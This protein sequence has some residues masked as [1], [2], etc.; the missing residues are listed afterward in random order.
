MFLKIT[1]NIF[2]FN[3]NTKNVEVIYYNTSKLCPKPSNIGTDTILRDYKDKQ[4]KPR[5]F[6]IQQVNNSNA[7]L[8]KS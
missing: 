5:N 1:L 7:N 8:N 3:T 4:K 2:S 6:D